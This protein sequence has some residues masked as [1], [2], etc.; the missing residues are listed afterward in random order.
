M[1]LSVSMNVHKMTG[2]SGKASEKMVEICKAVVARDYQDRIMRFFDLST[3]QERLK[4][5][6]TVTLEYMVPD[7]NWQLARFIAKNRNEQGVV[8][9]VLYVTRE[10]SDVMLRERN[11][12]MAA[13]AANR[14]NEAKQTFF[15][16]WPMISGH[17]L[18][19]FLDLPILPKRI[20]T[21]SLLS[22]RTW[23]SCSLQGVIFSGWWMMLRIS[24][25][26]RADIFIL[27]LHFLM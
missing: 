12:F 14:E 1:K 20:L 25:R 2:V 9:K 18:T 15:Q 27:S 13:E 3:L 23:T 26:S 11:W 8:T 16:E 10:V 6:D 19:Q 17:P 4:N 7:G 21:R 22:V 5:T 24:A